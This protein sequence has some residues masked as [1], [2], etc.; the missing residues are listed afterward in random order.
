MPSDC[1]REE[2]LATAWQTDVTRRRDDQDVVVQRVV[3]LGRGVGQAALRGLVHLGRAFHLQ[4][5]VWPLL[6]ELLSERVE[7]ILLLQHVRSGWT[8]GLGL[9]RP[10]HSLM[11]AVLLRMP[12]LDALVSDAEAHP[13]R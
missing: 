7:A 11:L 4:G 3:E 12:W 8:S 2:H 5:F 1:V 13:P 6:V 9:Q 10:V